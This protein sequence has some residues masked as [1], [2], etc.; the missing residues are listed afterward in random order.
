MLLLIVDSLR[1]DAVSEEITPNMAQMYKYPCI[2]SNNNTEPS[3]TTILTGKPPLEH[4]FLGNGQK[5][6]KDILREH[7]PQRDWK[8]FSPAI[9]FRPYFDFIQGKH[10]EEVDFDLG[11]KP[12]IIHTMD[13]HDYNCPDAI[14]KRFYKG[15]ES[16][17]D[18]REWMHYDLSKAMGWGHPWEGCLRTS[19][20]GWLKAKYKGATH[21]VD[22]WVGE[23]LKSHKGK[24][25]ITAD[26]GEGWGERGIVFR[27]QGLWDEL[28]YVPLMTNFQLPELKLYYH[29][30]LLNLIEGKPVPYREWTYSVEST[31]QSG[32]RVTTAD[33][34]YLIHT[35][36]KVYKYP[37]Y[38]GDMSLKPAVDNLLERFPDRRPAL[39]EGQ[40]ISIGGP[41]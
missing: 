22:K 6:G 4:G 27:H 25:F 18:E 15:F 17:P 7:L 28:V 41:R 9:V 39:L 26:H 19:D 10:L 3:L 38:M 12:T 30:D 11:K 16:I 34:R 14:A 31:W 35:W 24:I 1:Y 29:T 33:S 5:D 13:V 40:K 37:D 36:N 21:L 8:L 20:A 2:A 32:I 23:L